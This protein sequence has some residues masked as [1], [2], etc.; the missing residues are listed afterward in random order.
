MTWLRE[1][2]ACATSAVPFIPLSSLAEDPLLLA[3]FKKLPNCRGALV[4]TQPIS[5]ILNA[6]FGAIKNRR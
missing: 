2:G 4:K 6:V 1:Y 5:E 3:A